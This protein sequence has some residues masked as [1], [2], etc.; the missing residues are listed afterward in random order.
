MTRTI[1]NIE[2]LLQRIV[3]EDARKHDVIADTRRMSVV[4]TTPAPRDLTTGAHEVV[5]DTDEAQREHAVRETKTTLYLYLDGDEGLTEFA[6]TDHSLGQMA[7]D[8]GIPKRYFDRMKVDAPGLFRNNVHHWLYNEPKARLVRGL[9]NGDGPMTGRAWMS[10]KFRRLDNME[11]AR[12]LLPEFENLG[13]P[14]EFHQ[15]AVTDTK[16][17][18]RALFPRLE[19]DVK[20]VGDTVRWGV[21]ITN[22]EIGAGSLTISSFVL[23]LA[24]TNG[25]V[26]DKVLNARHIGKR[27]DVGVLSNEA[28]A[29]DD[30]AFWLAARDELRALCT[31]AAFQ[32][33]VDRLEG[34]SD[35]R[36]LSPVAA[37]KVLSNEYGLSD[38]EQESIMLQFVGGGLNGQWGMLNAITA[39]AQTVES[40]DR[41]AELEGI[42][43]Q[44]A[45]MPENAWA[46]VALAVK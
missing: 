22:S 38:D 12:T 41:Q 32:T 34:L 8:L 19:R 3:A 18:I 27:E 4:V 15:A 10:D 2:G 25:M 40:F 13:M 45:Q 17:H 29:A 9:T 5:T 11:I 42:G 7:T 33:V 6:M 37:T 36:V 16:L 30:V 21:S 24:C 43:W 31:E 1:E 35:Q 39:V 14:V 23:R 44:L 46:K 28:L 26:A 20:A